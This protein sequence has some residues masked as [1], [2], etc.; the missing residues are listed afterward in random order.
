MRETYCSNL[1]KRYSK[2]IFFVNQKTESREENYDERESTKLENETIK[3]KAYTGLAEKF[4]SSPFC[5]AAR[6][7]NFIILRRGHFQSSLP[8]N[9]RRSHSQEIEKSEAQAHPVNCGGD[10]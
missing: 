2:A 6:Q 8:W 10:T 1:V 7:T 4:L 3:T 9:D 5:K